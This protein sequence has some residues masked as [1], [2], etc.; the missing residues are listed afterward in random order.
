MTH[1]IPDRIRE[2]DETGDKEHE[3]MDISGA[4]VYPWPLAPPGLQ[5]SSQGSLLSGCNDLIPGSHL[6]ADRIT[7]GP[8]TC[9]ANRGAERNTNNPAPEPPVTI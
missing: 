8:S 7:L 3:I 9:V 4:G 5:V 1:R 6:A 2:T